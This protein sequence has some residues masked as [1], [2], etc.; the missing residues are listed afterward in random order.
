MAPMT[1]I[2]VS[3]PAR[4]AVNDRPYTTTSAPSVA[5]IVPAFE[6]RPRCASNATPAASTTG[7]AASRYIAAMFG[8]WNG[9][10]ARGNP[11]TS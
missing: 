6:P 5:V 2:A 8:Y 7:S 9:P 3:I 11:N 4:E 1:A 10:L